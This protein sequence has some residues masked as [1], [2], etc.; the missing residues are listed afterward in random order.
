MNFRLQSRKLQMAFM[1]LKHVTIGPIRHSLLEL[2][3]RSAN[4]NNDRARPFCYPFREKK[5]GEK[6]QNLLLFLPNHS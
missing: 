1:T 3:A 4:N 6:L 5:A 2:K